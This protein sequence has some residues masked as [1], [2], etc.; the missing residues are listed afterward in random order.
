M[1]VS[2]RIPN[3]ASYV[4]N[5]GADLVLYMRAGKTLPPAETDRLWR[6]LEAQ[7][8]KTASYHLD[9]YVGLK[10]EQEIGLDPFW[11]TGT[12]FTADGDLKTQAVFESY[13]INHSWLPAACVSDETYHGQF[14]PTLATDIVFVGKTNNYHR[15]WPWR[16]K[17]L[18][19]LRKR[20]RNQF[21]VWTHGSG[22]RDQ[23]LNDLYASA[24][25][26]V[27]DTLALPGHEYYWS[28]RYYETMGRGGFL[29]APNVPGLEL[30]FDEGTHYVGYEVGDI[31]GLC[32][33][34]DAYLPAAMD[35]ARIAEQGR[36]HVARKHTYKRRVAHMLD[37]VEL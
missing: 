16:A 4:P 12:V 24:K 15:E 23:R 30:H 8:T 31:E 34:I 19:A 5:L 3:L 10:R 9:L 13:G 27:G 33:M 20:Y 37:V 1:C 29:I 18:E 28:D 11:R 36:A 6:A 26:V 2:E 7:G 21:K 22:M 17:M 25:I 35:R 14:D 32:R